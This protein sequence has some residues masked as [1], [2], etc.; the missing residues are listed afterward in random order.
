ML[1]RAAEPLHSRQGRGSAP[2]KARCISGGRTRRALLGRT[3]DAAHV[4]RRT[5]G[6]PRA[7]TSALEW[8]GRRFATAEP[9]ALVTDQLGRCCS[10]NARPSDASRIRERRSVPRRRRVTARI[11][12]QIEVG[13]G[14][15][16]HVHL[17]SA[18]A[19][20]LVSARL[21]VRTLDEGTRWRSA[22]R[23]RLLGRLQLP[24]VVIPCRALAVVQ[25]EQKSP[26]PS[27]RTRAKRPPRGGAGHISAR[28]RAFGRRAAAAGAR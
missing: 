12:G 19:R 15:G 14:A 4:K 9:E 13:P 7:L 22:R 24:G 3:F 6:A 16:R 25:L 11:H 17:A 26:G 10:L 18:R 21:G 28:V 2:R 27:R 23:P 20:P 5:T 8:Y 1:W